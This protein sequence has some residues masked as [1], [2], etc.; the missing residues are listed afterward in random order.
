MSNVRVLDPV[1]SPDSSQRLHALPEFEPTPALDARVLDTLQR[2]RAPRRAVVGAALAAG[3][4]AAALLAWRVVPVSP[5]DDPGEAWIARTRALE[6]DLAGLRRDAPATP[7]VLQVEA[8]LTRIDIALQAA[9]DRGA[10]A[11]ELETMWRQ[12]AQALDTLIAVYRR[13]EAIVRI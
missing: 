9:Y 1:L 12:R 3:L 8:D 11:A 10:A 7:A 13:P 6:A 4:A 2:A 5:A